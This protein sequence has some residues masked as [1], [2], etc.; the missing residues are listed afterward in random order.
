VVPGAW[1]I[2]QGHDFAEEIEAALREALPYATVFT[3]V[4]PADD[5]RSFEDAALDRDA[6][7]AS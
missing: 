6:S 1:T 4:E 5:P 3:H 2:R 7:G